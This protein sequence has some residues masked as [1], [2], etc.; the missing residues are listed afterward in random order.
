MSKKSL[1]LNKVSLSYLLRRLGAYIVDWYLY[2]VL[3]IGF[4]AFYSTIKGIEPVYFMT[5]EHYERSDA[6]YAMIMM[7][8]I[9]LICFVLLVKFF[10]G[11]TIGKKIFKLRIVSV[12]GE[13]VLLNQLFIRE[14][15]GFLVIEGSFSPISSYIR[16]YLAMQFYDIIL[17]IR[18][19]Y[20]ISFISLLCLKMY[21][22]SRMIHDIVGKTKVIEMKLDK[23]EH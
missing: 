15:V 2:S 7:L 9:H 11:Q 8:L 16:T 10:K 1:M 4:N 5:L 6:T 12:S 22:D 18:I 3:L 14:L 23:Y 21:K 17:L 13:E 19:W 20:L